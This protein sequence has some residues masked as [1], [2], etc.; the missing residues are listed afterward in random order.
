MFHCK[1]ID[2]IPTTPVFHN[3]HV[4]HYFCKNSLGSQV[5]E[6]EEKEKERER[7]RAPPPT[8]DL[9]LSPLRVREPLF[10]S[11][12]SPPFTLRL[13]LTCYPALILRHTH[14]AVPSESRISNVCILI[15]LITSMNILYR[16]NF[17]LTHL[18][19]FS[20]AILSSFPYTA[21][22]QQVWIYG[23]IKSARCVYTSID[24]YRTASACLCYILYMYI[25]SLYLLASVSAACTCLKEG[26]YKTN[27]ERR[28][29]V[30][31][32]FKRRE[33]I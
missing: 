1:T 10:L 31:R 32:V 21:A 13:F 26:F 15:N 20:K 28:S 29:T 18:L 2:N 27:C 9:L 7:M 25:P 6:I 17:W 23:T 12:S 14:T 33:S 19:H 16:R 3:S 4:L 5:S 24:I 11:L 8:T 22:G 30:F